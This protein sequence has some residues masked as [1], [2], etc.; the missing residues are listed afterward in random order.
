MKALDAIVTVL[1][2]IAGLNL[3]VV[4]VSNYN[5]IE[6]VFGYS[7]ALTHIIYILFGL[8]GLYHVFQWKGMGHR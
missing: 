5:V 1:L 8:S 4:G 2:I 7:S 3:G 6:Q